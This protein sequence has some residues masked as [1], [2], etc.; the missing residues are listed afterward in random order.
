MTREGYRKTSTTV[1][2]YQQLPIK[3]CS[4][5]PCELQGKHAINQSTGVPTPLHPAAAEA[6]KRKKETKLISMGNN[7]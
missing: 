6:R 4:D 5:A 1:G 7:I 2:Y 3:L